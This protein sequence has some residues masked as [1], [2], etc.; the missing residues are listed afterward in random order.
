MNLVGS[1]AAP[2]AALTGVRSIEA[3]LIAMAEFG[4]AYLHSEVSCPYYL[5]K[6][7]PQRFP[8]M[9]EWSRD[10]HTGALFFF[11]TASGR[12]LSPPHSS[13]H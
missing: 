12:P 4:V 11:I 7:H 2:I 9:L 5:P 13:I 3:K 8:T 10:A 6:C 1:F